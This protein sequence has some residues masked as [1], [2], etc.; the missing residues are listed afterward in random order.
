MPALAAGAIK[1]GRVAGLG[2]VGVRM[3]GSN[4]AVTTSDKFHIGSCTKAMTSTLAGTYIDGS[5]LRWTSKIAEVF[6]ERRDKID[7]AF[8]EVTLEMLLTHRAGLPHDGPSY[9]K[10]G[11]PVNEQRLA[12]LDAVLAKPP[13]NAVDTFNYSNAGYVIAGAMLERI[14]GRTWEKL[15]RD[16]VFKPLGMDSAGFGV[17][18]TARQADQPW[19]HVK[20]GGKFVARYGDNHRGIGPAGT[21]HCSITDYLK[22][23]GLHSSVGKRPPGFITKATCERLHQPA[24]DGYAFGWGVVERGWARGK[25]L[26]HAGSNGMNY[27]VVWLA[28]ETDFALAVA[29]N[30]SDDQTP[31]AL[32]KVA[33]E[34]VKRYSGA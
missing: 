21:V 23:A 13:P 6:P 25:A 14:T 17:A 34:L 8:R 5:K 30:A 22:F 9:G 3:V 24:K 20:Q 10:A 15:M 18:M 16:K 19:P 31:A 12:Y 26:T 1:A 2:A 33:G 28:P 27:F 29:T 32:D 7:A 4:E 11:A